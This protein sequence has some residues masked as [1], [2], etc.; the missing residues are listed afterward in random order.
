VS[1]YITSNLP[2]TPEQLHLWCLYS[3]A[4]FVLLSFINHFV[5][6]QRSQ[7]RA[8]VA[9]KQSLFGLQFPYS[10][11]LI[12][13]IIDT[14]ILHQIPD[15]EKFVSIAGITLTIFSISTLFKIG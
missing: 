3:T 7:F 12:F 5:R 1:P 11:L 6:G 13:A 4:I 8:Q 9:I 15:I 2:K 10:F 14:S